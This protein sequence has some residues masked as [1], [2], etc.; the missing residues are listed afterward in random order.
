[1]LLKWGMV[2]II[3]EWLMVVE[4]I[5]VVGNFNVIFCE[6]GI[7]IFDGYYICNCFD[8]LVLFVLCFFMYLF[9]MIDF[10]YGIGKFEYVF[11]MVMVAI[12]VGIDFL[13]IEVYFNLVKVM[14]DGF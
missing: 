7:C 13:M 5:F 9:I 8:L 12:V 14:F 4:Y 11:F 6:W 3:D 2:V 1:M 10:S